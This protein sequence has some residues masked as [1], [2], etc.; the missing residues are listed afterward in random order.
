MAK[1][2]NPSYSIAAGALI[3]SIAATCQ[4][5]TFDRAGLFVCRLFVGVGMH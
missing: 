3:W 4:A 5:A 2:V 1:Q